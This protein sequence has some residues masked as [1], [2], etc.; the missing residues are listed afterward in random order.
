MKTKIFTIAI[1]IAI[2]FGF[3]PSAIEL[4]EYSS[5]K[6]AA[7]FELIPLVTQDELLVKFEQ[8][9]SQLK[10][11]K[12][13]DEFF[14]ATVEQKRVEELIGKYVLVHGYVAST[15]IRSELMTKQLNGA[16]S[17]ASQNLSAQYGAHT[18]ISARKN[19]EALLEPLEANIVTNTQALRFALYGFGWSV[20]VMLLVFAFRAQNFMHLCYELFSGRLLFASIFWPF[21]AREYMKVQSD[22]YKSV[23]AMAKFA[24]VNLSILMSAVL[25]VGMAQAQTGT[26]KTSNGKRSSVVIVD[27][28]AQAEDGRNP[29]TVIA[30]STKKDGIIIESA[31]ILNK[32]G[33]TQFGVVGKEVY[34]QPGV[35][36][37]AYGGW[38]GDFRKTQPNAQR[39]LGGIRL[40]ASKKLNADNTLTISVPFAHYEQYIKPKLKSAFFSTG[41]VFDRFKSKFRFGGEYTFR[42]EQG[43]KASL[44]GGPFIGYNIFS[45]VRVEGLLQFSNSGPP[46]FRLRTVFAF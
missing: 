26:K 45:K 22:D 33:V 16:M 29:E 9:L 31:T 30:L 46:R 32:N 8:T 17:Y 11:S 43:S 44:S 36:V 6:Q 35:T 1:A 15:E 12:T 34:K 28:S 27:Q 37:D 25:S 38:R 18:M 2:C 19:Y 3:L 10:N 42:K 5:Q 41:Q 24:A 21:F 14:S 4:R 39:F 23:A 13:P 40:F 20:F 7:K